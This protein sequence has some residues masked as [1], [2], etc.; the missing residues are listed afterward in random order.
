MKR[1]AALIFLIAIFGAMFLAPKWP[2][3]VPRAWATGP[4]ASPSA[5]ATATATATRTATPTATPT[6]APGIYV[7]NFA[8]GS[9]TGYALSSSGNTPPIVNLS[10]A[11]TLLSEPTKLKIDSSGNLYVVDA[12]PASVTEYLSGSNGDAAPI[13]RIVG[14]GTGLN[15]PRGLALDS[16]GNIYV[17]NGFGYD[18]T[19]YAAGAN[20]NASPIS[21]ITGAA[22]GLNNGPQAVAVDTAGNIYVTTVSYSSGAVYIF[23]A[24]ANGNA[25]PVAT[26]SGANTGLSDP[27]GIG[28]D[29]SGNIYVANYHTSAVTVYP[30]LASLS[31]Q[32]NYPNIVPTR[33]ITGANTALAFPNDLW[34]DAN[35]NIYVANEN[36]GAGSITVYSGGSSGN[37]PPKITIAG[38]TTLLDGPQG[39]VALGALTL[40]TSTPTPAP[41]P[42]QPYQPIPVHTGIGAGLAQRN[43]INAR[44]S[45]AVPISPTLL[46]VSSAQLAGVPP[47]AGALLYCVDC[48]TNAGCSSGGS[49]AVAFGF[50]GGWVCNFGG[51]GGLSSVSN[52]TNITGA[53]SGGGTLLS[54]GWSGNLATSRGGTGCGAASIFSALPGSP[55]VGTTCTITDAQSCTVGTAVSGGYSTPCQ[56]V[57]N[58]SNW[59]PAGN[60]LGSVPNAVLYANTYTGATWAEQVNAAVTALGSTGGTVD[61]RGI[62]CSSLSTADENVSLGSNGIAVSLLL[63]ACTYPLGTHSLLLFNGTSVRGIGASVLGGGNGTNISCTGSGT[64]VYYGAPQPWTSGGWNISLSNLRLQGDGTSGG[65]G[66]NWNDLFDST[67]Y[68]VAIVDFDTG[69]Q[70]GGAGSSSYYDKMYSSYVGAVTLGV[71][72]TSSANADEYDGGTVS[73]Q[74]GGTGINVAA[75][76][77]HNVIRNV[78]IEN[79][80]YPITISGADTYVECGYGSAVTLEVGAQSNMIVGTA[81]TAI[82]DSSGNL[83]NWYYV[84]G[85]GGGTYPPTYLAGKYGVGAW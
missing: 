76:A 33:T 14:A 79:T 19:V 20:G 15:F 49:G 80:T 36:G 60:A 2:P 13:A 32:P 35:N 17:A 23:S 6:T 57:W 42:V 85:A 71:S 73:A 39:I 3:G 77:N 56:I 4:T 55:A 75:G 11:G 84:L 65:I 18:V 1:I 31:S 63:N 67:T 29:S 83:S 50:G 9:V 27:D 26:I 62:P 10:G 40:P 51:G 30:P 12:V 7:G 5:T 21:T 16:S 72:F 25:T 34:L 28:V 41:P 38:V 8:N 37:V 59:M 22:T 61:A 81:C 53:L 24:G 46:P 43:D 68:N 78:D 54:L 74:A 52:D 70:F 66:L 64:C 48:Q 69:V 44:F 58:G 45:G 47:I 82:G